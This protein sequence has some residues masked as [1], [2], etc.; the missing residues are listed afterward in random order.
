MIA[1]D[2][3]KLSEIIP[4]TFGEAIKIYPFLKCKPHEW[5]NRTTVENTQWIINE[6]RVMADVADTRANAINILLPAVFTVDT[7]WGSGKLTHLGTNEK[8]PLCGS[9]LAGAELTD[10]KIM[11]KENGELLE[12]WN[13]ASTVQDPKWVKVSKYNYCKRCLSALNG[14]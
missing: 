13:Q 1:R 5:D 12:Y 3:E 7:H 6:L 10:T 9:K 11:M 2:F 4:G 14:R 8:M